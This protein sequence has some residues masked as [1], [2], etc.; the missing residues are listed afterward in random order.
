M[1]AIYLY[2]QAGFNTELRSDT[3]WGMICWGIRNI[4]GQM[5]LEEYIDSCL[6]GVPEFII[7]SAFPFKESD[8]GK[9]HF[10][11]RPIL[12]S[13]T[14]EDVSEKL[15]KRE[16]I[17]KSTQDKS[18]KKKQYIGIEDFEKL[19]N[20][21][22]DLQLTLARTDAPKIKSF[23]FTHNTIDRIKGGTLKKDNMGQLFHVDEYFF[24]TGE[25]DNARY[26]LYFF[27][28]GPDMS[29]LEGAMRWL[30]HVGIGGDRNIGKGKFKIAMADFDIRQPEGS[31]AMTTFSL[32]LPSREKKE[33]DGFITN[34]LFNY[35]I[36]ERR[37]FYGFL[38]YRQFMKPPVKMFREGSVF[39][40]MD[41]S[42]PG[43]LIKISQN[44]QDNDYTHPV[45]HYGI[46]F[47]IKMKIS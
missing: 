22:G 12:P 45:Y 4:Y 18:S 28:D 19:A 42:I 10:V 34:P 25:H 9:E 17:I 16:A 27:A 46:G 35:L 6:T 41:I 26:G 38:K 7:S 1:I 33:L 15:T 43:S 44:N 13:G 24:D 32:F 21:E 3:L 11:P 31:N 5:A 37:G 2:P 30:S 23:S 8:H 36:E 14:Y 39:P 47:M 29:K 20:G 40:A